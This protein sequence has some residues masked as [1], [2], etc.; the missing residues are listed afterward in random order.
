MA[1]IGG[2]ITDPLGCPG[3]V[4]GGAASDAASGALK[5]LADGAFDFLG[6]VLKLLTTFWMSVPA[7][8]LTSPQSAVRLLQDQLRPI[9]MFAMV[10]GLMCAAVKIMWT[11]RSGTPGAMGEVFKGIAL[12]VVVTGAG[13]LIVSVLM[14]AFDQWANRDPQ[15]GFRRRRGR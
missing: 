8:D 9:A 7:P 13:A 1:G 12:T 6:N 15:S 5:A 4:V 3:Q 14:S 11:A 2:C 10:I